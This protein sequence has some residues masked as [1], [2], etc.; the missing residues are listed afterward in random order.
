M[1][2]N[3]R[4]RDHA[5]MSKALREHSARVTPGLRKTASHHHQETHHQER[6]VP[7]AGSRSTSANL[8]YRISTTAVELT[9]LQ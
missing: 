2:S 1:P 6:V 8:V 4:V 3:A 5:R 7:H 9:S